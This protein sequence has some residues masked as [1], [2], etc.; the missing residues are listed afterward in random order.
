MEKDALEFKPFGQKIGSYKRRF[1]EKGKGKASVM[2]AELNEDD[3]DVVTFEIYHVSLLPFYSRLADKS[4]RQPGT[5]Q[6]LGNTIGE[7]RF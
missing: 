6:G 1:A 4:C 2:D 5:R 7:C 3:E